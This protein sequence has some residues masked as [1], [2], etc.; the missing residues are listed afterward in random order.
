MG[1]GPP[2]RTGRDQLRQ[3]EALIERGQATGRVVAFACAHSAA[4]LGPLLEERGATVVAVPC[5]GS[6]HTSAI[7]Y[8]VRAG[9]RAALVL[10][11]PPRDCW[12]REGPRWLMERIYHEREAELKGRVD[13]R[14]VKVGVVAAFDSAGAV[15]V[16]AELEQELAAFEPA[17]AETAIAIDTE[18]VVPAAE[19]ES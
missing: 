9:A 17:V 6:L 3:V 12:S 10:G 7:E 13:R 1:V 18:C 5:V 15:A 11:C 4:T 16:L 19:A 14:R 2:G 8:V